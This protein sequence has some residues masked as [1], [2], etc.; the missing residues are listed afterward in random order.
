MYGWQ[1]A[2]DGK[3]MYLVKDN[4]EMAGFGEY[5]QEKDR[6]S[7]FKGN[8]DSKRNLGVHFFQRK[9][10]SSNYVGICRIK[11]INNDDLYDV[12]GN[13]LILKVVPRFNVGI[14]ELL[15]YI[16]EDDEF[17]RYL[18]PQT[19][20]NSQKDKEIE[21]VDKNEIFYFFENEKLLKVEDGI[22]KENSIITVTVFLSLLKSLCKKPLMGRMIKD[23]ANL[24][25]KVKGKIVIEKNIRSNTMRGRNDRFYCRYLQYTDN[26]LENQVLKAALK[27]S[28]KYILDCFGV[29][30][31]SDN[32]YASMISYCSKMFRGVDDIKCSPS[33][34]KEL[35]FTG[36]YTYYKPVITLAQMIL[37][38]ISIESNGEVTTSGYI[39]PYAISMEKLFEVYVRAYLKKNGVKSYKEKAIEGIQIEKF[40]SK[41]DVLVEE[42][43]LSNPG[44]YINGPIKPDIILTDISTEKTA[45]FDVK[46]KNYK[47][48]DSRN[49]RLQLLAYSMM[50]NAD[51]VGL[52]L[53][54]LDEE[55]PVIFDA[56]KI[57]SSEKRLVKYHQLL[58]NMKKADNTVAEY[59]KNNSFT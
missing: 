17:D 57:N 41:T 13:E 33:D 49:D 10:Y 28:K 42:S 32:N 52:I 39:V 56:R 48:G 53:P 37:K 6:E 30:G 22:S 34:C 36:C 25:G 27:K 15:N 45:V 11:D 59:I 24:T 12:E 9:L 43:D 16:R 2:R 19:T 50:M 35:R 21:A 20:S 47:K 38:D 51:N 58:L 7:L 23:E 54:T 29:K 4:S 55:V 14:V 44:K 40:D 5:I 3:R 1:E 8:E 46:Y 31:R 18:A 26:I